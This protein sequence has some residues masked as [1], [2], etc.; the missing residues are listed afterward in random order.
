MSDGGEHQRDG[1]LVGG[2]YRLIE[3]IGSGGMGTVWRA[4]DEL[5]AREV[6]VKQPR[7]PGHPE[8]ESHRRAGH[9]LYREA[10]AAARVDHS[11][12]VTIHDVVE[13]DGI[14]WIVMELIRGESL[15]ELLRR[16]PLPPAESAR[17][18]LAVLGALRAAHA[19][20]IVHRDVKPANVL[21]GPHGR[22]V[23][24]DFGIAHVQ[25]EESLTASGEFVGSLE[26]IAPERMS[27][28]SAGPASDL[29][30]L[31]V[32]LYAAVEGWSP[33]RRT[34]LESTLAAI[35]AADLPEPKQAGPLG[36]LLVQLLAKDPEQRPGPEEVAAGLGA[37]AEDW[38]KVPDDA[39]AVAQ[40]ASDLEGFADDAGTVRLRG[41]AAAVPQPR[42]TPP[43]AP[44]QRT[45]PDA[46]EQGTAPNASG[47][48]SAPYPAEQ[49]SAPN[50][51]GQ[52]SE[53]D[54][55]GRRTAP[56]ASGQPSESDV[57]EQSTARA[58][59]EQGTAPNATG[60]PSEPDP[61]GRRTAPDASG[62]PSES[63][64]TEQPTARAAPEQGTAP[65]APEQPSE[66]DAAE[67]RT[68]LDPS[69]RRTAPDPSGRPSESDVTEQPTARAAPEQGTAPDA[70]EQP[71]EPDAAEQRTAP[72]P[73][74]RRT[75]PNAT[76]QPSAP[77]PAEQP[78]E[79]DA[80]ERRTAPDPSEQPTAPDPTQRPTK[81]A[82]RHPLRHPV[83]AV[84]LGILLTG[85]VWFATSS[86]RPDPDPDEASVTER[87]ATHSSAPGVVESARPTWI[88]HRE[89]DL[90][91]VLALPGDYAEAAR[92]GSA[93]D[94]PR[95]VVYALGN[96]IQVRLTQW[97][98]APGS[99]MTRAREAHATW[100]SY[101]GDART[102]Y[103]RTSF[104]GQ[105]AVLADTTYN[106][107][108]DPTRVM[109]LVIL[110]DDSRMYEL[111]V[112]MPKG[113]PDEKKGT[114][115]FK[116]ARDRLQIEADR[117]SPT[118]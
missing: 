19:V 16:G 48:P 97:D 116:G 42:T 11:S 95:L 41:E 21:L 89:K 115:V 54:P 76:G 112:D 15:H 45:A 96:T 104:D 58:A 39:A 55:S 86:F 6:A 7:L 3:R 70:P 40:E 64:V 34:T 29:W 25:G 18:G 20:G 2:R 100:D 103:T 10:R 84:L 8:D 35:L 5:V 44:E 114:A 80:P 107:A 108:E 32:L 57:T 30:S 27:G 118:P 78:S 60:Q 83:P 101:N 111:R 71:S 87:T 72:D 50:A 79:P 92:E 22:V 9:R 82:A 13:E 109:Q 88:E 63:D 47:Q 4:R 102:Q 14:P 68:A 37:V 91:A 17:I 81:A 26:F 59:P 93:E 113:T 74:G 46:S 69:G 31:G 23:L 56:D 24:T 1:R 43:D 66:P 12:A 61:S 38:P 62:R 99:P 90:A 94:P 105:E 75:A 33:F 73:S 36:P 117:A 52:P 106:T 28:R 67:Q 65:D 53:P 77:D 51:T 49:P 98:K 110:T 85:G